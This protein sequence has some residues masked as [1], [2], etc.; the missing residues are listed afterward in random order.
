MSYKSRLPL[1][2]AP[3]VLPVTYGVF[4]LCVYFLGKTYGYLAGFL[5]YWAFCIVFALI[6]LDQKQWKE[7]YGTKPKMLVQ[8]WSLLAFVPALGPLLM[9]FIP[10]VSAFTPWAFLVLGIVSVCNGVTEELFW[11]GVFI[12]SF[13]K[14]VIKAYVYPTLFFCLW[15]FALA[16]VEEVRYQGGA[17]ALVGGAL[18]LGAI[19]GWVAYR[20]QS[21]FVTTLAHIIVNFFAFSGLI[22]DNW[23]SQDSVL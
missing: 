19:W 9:A 13:R 6:V 1:W 15:H 17:W 4:Q 7:I 23:L 2:V 5:F 20:Q 11:R 18:M 22:A 14:D 8:G 10:S 16:G 12:A 21:V 3:L